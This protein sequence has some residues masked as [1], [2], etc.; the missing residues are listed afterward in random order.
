MPLTKPPF[1]L[2]FRPSKENIRILP[3]SDVNIRFTC[4]RPQRSLRRLCF[5]TCLS[6]CPRR[7]G[8]P[9]CMLGSHPHPLG[10]DIPHQEQTSLWEQTPRSRQ[11]PPPDQ[12]PL[13]RSRHPPTRAGTPRSR[14][15]PRSSAC[16][17]KRSTS[18]RYASYWNAILFNIPIMRSIGM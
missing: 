13:P 17:E 1:G 12:A 11:L 9:Q 8:L 7:G 3:L 4:Y 2:K 16:W 10:A 6:F 15:T 14:H 18:G 5:Y